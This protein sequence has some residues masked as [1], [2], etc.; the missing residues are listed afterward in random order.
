MIKNNQLFYNHLNEKKTR[1]HSFNKF[2]NYEKYEKYVKDIDI[3]EDINMKDYHYDNGIDTIL[4]KAA[5]GMGKTKKLKNL[6]NYHKNKKIVIVSFRRTLDRE[7]TQNFE[8]F[9]LYED[10]QSGTFDTNIHNKMVIQIDSFHKIRGE[11]DLLV[12]D[13]F[14]YTTLHLVERAKYKDAVYN[15]LIQYIRNL[16]IKIIS[17]DALLDE[18]IV[19]W[20]YHQRRCIKY[21]ENT[22]KRHSDIEIINYKNKIGVFVNDIIENLKENRKIVLPTNSKKFLDNLYKEIKLIFKEEKKCLFLTSENSD[23]INLENWSNYDIVGYTPTIVAGISYEKKH[24]D[25]IFAYFI[26]SSSCAEM[27]LQQLFRVRNI[28]DNEINLCIEN[29]DN[30]KYLTSIKDIEKYIIDS[31]SCLIDGVM[32]IKINRI[33]NKIIKDSYYYMYRDCQIKIFKSKNDYENV[34]LNLLKLQ[35]ITNVKNIDKEDLEKDKN[36]RNNIRET[37]KEFNEKVVEDII[38][39]DE[40]DDDKYNLLKNRTILTYSEKNMLKKKKFRKIYGYLGNISSDMYKKY[41]KKYE[42]FKNIN[43]LYT[44]K[45]ETLEFLANRIQIIE[46]NKI[47]SYEKEEAGVDSYG[48]VY[49]SANPYILHQSKKQQKTLIGLE[50]IK[51]IGADN[52]F[53]EN[54]FKINFEN[55]YKY[56]KEREY[57]IRLLFK[58]K[59]FDFNLIKMDFKGN[60]EMLKYVNARLRTLFNIHIKKCDKKS[61]EYIINGMDYWSNEIN[62]FKENEDLKLEMYV[63][64]MLS[65]MDF[66]I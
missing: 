56:L 1:L 60:H 48:N 39:S 11:I 33:Y 45:D 6:F 22:Y 61:D 10:I 2:H 19:K 24:F 38:K 27:S 14:S 29:K 63:K 42:Q 53:N 31:N 34:L 15:T 36:M 57:K 18:Y 44:L 35:G 8:G 41:S 55:F 51:M 58:C 30:N 26:N 3:Y 7:Y 43:T 13:E 4:V 64:A 9:M 12:L 52:I 17:M 20:F 32:G 37:S 59:E 65:N 40:I 16:D 23:D 47:S 66:D 46:D 28:N 49:T 62:P 54:K 5:M 21:V 50:L 25:K